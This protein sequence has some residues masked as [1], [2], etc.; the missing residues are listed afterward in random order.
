MTEELQVVTWNIWGIPFASHTVLTRPGRCGEHLAAEVD[1]TAERVVVCIQEAWS[2]K[3]GWCGLLV[4]L[5]RALERCACCIPAHK[6][7]F[8]PRTIVAEV[9]AVNSCPTLFATICATLGALCCPCAALSDHAT[10]RQIVASLAARGLT[11]AVGLKGAAGLS[12]SPSKLMDSGLLIVSNVRPTASGFVAFEATGSE[13]GA[14]KG[15]LW[16][17]LPAASSGAGSQLV[18]TTHMHADQPSAEIEG[19]DHSPD[20]PFAE[21]A[22][23][24][25]AQRKQLVAAVERLRVEHAV[26]LVVVC[27]DF[28]EDA[29]GGLHADMTGAP[30]RLARLTDCAAEG[31]CLKDDGS[32]RVEELDHIY[33]GVADGLEL[34]S[35]QP[36]P[37]IRTPYSDHSIVCCRLRYS[38]ASFV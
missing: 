21:S 17:V 6:Q 29:N 10:K 16:A 11:H 1:L 19:S 20:Q 12:G 37:A 15:F 23:A 8:D 13:G 7:T 27:G 14:N 34:A 26:A 4:K 24:R 22:G 2:Y 32:G 31:T 18:V 3:V 35:E 5:A 9:V 25:V 30:L 38:A 36:T 33:A 28:N